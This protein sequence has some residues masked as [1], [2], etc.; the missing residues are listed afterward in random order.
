[1]EDYLKIYTIDELSD[2][3]KGRG[4]DRKKRR[5][6]GTVSYF[7]GGKNITGF[8]YKQMKKQGAK[9]LN[10]ISFGEAEENRKKTTKSLGNCYSID[11]LSDL[12]KG[13]SEGVKRGW[14]KRRLR[15]KY[16]S[17]RNQMST[18]ERSKPS[19][20]DLWPAGARERYERG[21]ERKMKSGKEL[22]QHESSHYN[23]YMK[24]SLGD[25]YNRKR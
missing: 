15:S 5:S 25:C 4:P 8:D 6:K 22:E 13:T 2:L 16:D 10:K 14:E 17:Q 12:K 20:P 19:P 9:G 24:K 11:E 3:K 21:I 7:S 23:Q 1:M 18:E